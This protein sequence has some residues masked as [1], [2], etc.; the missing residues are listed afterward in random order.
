MSGY[1]ISFYISVE[2]YWRLPGGERIR[3][4]GIDAPE[5]R[6]AWEDASGKL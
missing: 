3:L 6:Q 5:S 1:A 4:N 2:S